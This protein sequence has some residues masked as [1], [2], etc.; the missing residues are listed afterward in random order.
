MFIHPSFQKL[1]R[2]LLRH[3]LIALCVAGFVGILWIGSPAWA[4]PVAQGGGTVPLP[5]A[6]SEGAPIAT[7]TP[8]ADDESS[9]E[10]DNGGSG[11]G[12]SSTENLDSSTPNIVFPQVPA[13]SPA[14][15][16]TAKVSVNALNLRE[17]P[18]TSFNTLGNLPANTE[19]AVLSRSEDGTWWYICCIPGTQTMGWVSAQ[20]L[21]PNFDA[22]QANTLLPLFGTTPVA[23]AAT[24]A[25]QPTQQTQQTQQLAE[26]PLSVDFRIDPYFVWQGITATLTITVNNPNAVDAVN[27][28]LSDEL[29]PTLTLVE[30][31][32][33]ADGTVETVAAV[34]G[35]PLLL[36]RWASIPADTA[37]SATI[38]AAVSPQLADGEVIDNLVATRARNVAYSTSAV[39]I[40]MPPVLPPDFQ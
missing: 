26:L 10:S 38:V 2:M 29:P 12:S 17:G 3:W 31:T 4:A 11:N 8:Q 15:S 5:T 33:D 37:V 25:P 16:Q 36:F 23:A 21:T 18:G 34:S 28:L 35:S 19:V 9:N 27:V 39:T 40:G 7:A 6:T 20:L 24:A 32:V 30:A 22:A 13:G 14:T 1:E